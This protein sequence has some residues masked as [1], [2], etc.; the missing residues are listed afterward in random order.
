MHR[1]QRMNPLPP[2]CFAP[3]ARMPVPILW[4]REQRAA[5]SRARRLDPRLQAASGTN[6]GPRF[7][8][9]DFLVAEVLFCGFCLHPLP[10]LAL[11]AT[12]LPQGALE[13]LLRGLRVAG[14]RTHP[15]VFLVKGLP[16]GFC[17]NLARSSFPSEGVAPTQGQPESP[18]SFGPTA[19]SEPLSPR[20]V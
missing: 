15:D 17:F 5:P 16:D 10:P 8:P 6:A 2:P 11:M 19:P 7:P 14:F 18:L 3:A 20:F 12:P 13:T 4:A 9:G 1:D